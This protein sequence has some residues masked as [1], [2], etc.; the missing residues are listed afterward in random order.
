[1]PGRSCRVRQLALVK[2]PAITC[3]VAAWAGATNDGY[4]RGGSPRVA[5]AP[6]REARGNSHT[7]ATWP[8]WTGLGPHL[9]PWPASRRRRPPPLAISTSAARGSTTQH[10]NGT[11]SRGGTAVNRKRRLGGDCPTITLGIVRYCSLVAS[12][13]RPAHT[14]AASRT[15]RCGSA[16]TAPH[17]PRPLISHSVTTSGASLNARIAARA[18]VFLNPRLDYATSESMSNWI[19]QRILAEGVNPTAR[20]DGLS[21]W[22]R[23]AFPAGPGPGTCDLLERG[24]QLG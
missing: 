3:V 12:S 18:G 20:H 9:P 1:L 21:S 11:A 17:Q 19:Y 24:V 5:T 2:W 4:N 14:A 13:T 10:G 23:G 7:P 16:A 6:S 22:R 8:A 15:A